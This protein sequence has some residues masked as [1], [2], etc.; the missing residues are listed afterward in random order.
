FYDKRRYKQDVLLEEI[1]C[2]NLCS[3]NITHSDSIAS[4]EFG[5]L[6]SPDILISHADGRISLDIN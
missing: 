3:N 1:T 4:L 5:Q 6:S 2:N